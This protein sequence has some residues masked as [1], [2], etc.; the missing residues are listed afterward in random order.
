MRYGLLGQK[1]SHSY[2][3]QIHTALAGYAYALI[4]VEPEDLENFMQCKDFDGINVTIPYKKA[5]L[6]FC[7]ALSPQAK[8]LGAVNTIVKQSDG[9]LWGHNTDYCGFA[10]MVRI[11][12]LDVHG[13]K[14]L[15]LGSGGA[16]VTAFA[17]MEDLGAN[18]VMVSRNGE[19]N[20]SNLHLHKDAAVI[21]NATPVGMYPNTGRSPIDLQAFRQL[22]GVLDLIY[23][24][25]RTALLLQAE[26]LGLIAQNGLYM[27][28]AQAKES[29]EYFA[30]RKIPDEKIKDVYTTLKREMENILLIGMPGCGKSTIGMALAQATGRKFV[31]SDQLIVEQIGMS[32]PAYMQ[33]YGLEQFR[34]EETRVLQEIC[35]QSSFVIATGGGCVTR[36]ENYDLLRQN[37]LVVWIQRDVDALPVD[38][39]PL[40]QN[41]SLQAM[42]EARSPLYSRFSHFSVNNDQSL[43]AAVQ[44]ILEVYK[45]ATYENIDH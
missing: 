27:L 30:G 24:P 35:K 42:Y 1:L 29:A 13:K 10:E 20:Y 25:A 17:V 32:I 19:N 9:T 33:M 23:N 6:P 28:V 3:P 12:G 8:R 16:G 38:G 41:G 22:E 43:E 45:G 2:S 21:V 39:R 37:S 14:V 26:S 4:P 31:D 36:E 18:V 34:K 15:V 44:A 7:D 11:S 40:S 5:V